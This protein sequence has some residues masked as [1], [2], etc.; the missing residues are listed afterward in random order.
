[1]WELYEEKIYGNLKK[2]P[3]KTNKLKI[4]I[5]SIKTVF[6][7][8]I[9]AL[10]SADFGCELKLTTDWLS[11]CTNLGRP[12]W[13]LVMSAVQLGHCEHNNGTV[14]CTKTGTALGTAVGER[15]WRD[16]TNIWYRVWAA[17]AW[18]RTELTEKWHNAIRAAP[19]PDQDAHQHVCKQTE[20]RNTV[21]IQLIKKNKA[22]SSALLKATRHIIACSCSWLSF[23]GAES[24]NSLQ[25]WISLNFHH[26]PQMNHEVCLLAV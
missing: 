9:T 21:C 6:R 25:C 20:H 17:V 3:K 10:I 1:M 24:P 19:T 22:I 13:V 7:R 12:Q 8:L 18:T 4:I 26:K 5:P 16:I 15:L 23:S 2:K 11:H 14:V